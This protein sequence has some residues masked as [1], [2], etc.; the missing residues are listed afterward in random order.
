MT[1][2]FA[3]RYDCWK[4]EPLENISTV[5]EDAAINYLLDCPPYIDIA[6]KEVSV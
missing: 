3:S 1:E 4:C 5:D 6:K 2:L